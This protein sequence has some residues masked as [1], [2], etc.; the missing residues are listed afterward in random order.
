[1]TILP[2]IL[3]TRTLY[4]E[5]AA[6]LSFALVFSS[7]GVAAE[8][9]GREVLLSSDPWAGIEEMVVVGAGT[10]LL[11]DVIPT[12][13]IGFDAKDLAMERIHNVSDLGQFTPNLEIKTSFAA[14]NPVIFVRGV[15]LD[16][17]N[18][19]SAGAV[20]IYQDGVYMNSPAGQLFGFFDLAGVDV[21]RGAQSGGYR[22]ASAAAILANSRRPGGEYEAVAS[23]T[24]GNYDL[25]ETEL[26]V[27]IPLGE[28]LSSRYAGKFEKRSGYVKNRCNGQANR[29]TGC[30]ALNFPA[31][32]SSSGYTQLGD[33]T[34]VHG[35]V[36]D[37]DNWAARA[38]YLLDF[39]LGDGSME[40][41]LNIHGG[42][43]LGQA[44][45]FQH[46]GFR[47][48]SNN[49]VDKAY[50][51]DRLGYQDT[52][53]GRTRGDQTG[54]P[55]A[56]DYNNGGDEKLNLLG[57]SLQGKWEISDIHTIKSISAVEWHDRDTLENTDGGPRNLLTSR[58]QDDAW[59]FSQDLRLDSS[60]TE[61]LETTIGAYLLREDLDA[62]NLY[63]T[64]NSQLQQE[65][66]QDTRS[67]SL[68]G[69]LTWDLLSW[70]LGSWD[71]ALT[72]AGS[73]R[74]TH[75]FKQLETFTFAGNNNFGPRGIGTNADTGGDTFTGTSGSA[76]LTYDILD[77][78]NLYVKY[79]RGWKPGHINGGA[80]YSA[81]LV[82]PVKP[83]TIDAYEVGTAMSFFED[84]LKLSAAYF[85]TEFTDLQIFQLEQDAGDGFPLPQLIS[86]SGALI[87]GFEAELE[88]EPVENLIVAFNMGYLNT[89]YTDFV[90]VLFL[91][92][93]RS[94]D[95]LIPPTFIRQEIVY[96]GNPMISAP[97]WQLSG[98]VQYALSMGRAGILTPRFSFSW[99]DETFFNASKGRGARGDLPEGTN[100]QKAYALLHASLAWANSSESMSITGW[101]RNIAQQ[102]YRVTSFDVS[103]RAFGFVLDVY[104]P[105]RTFGVTLN[106]KY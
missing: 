73:V 39:P 31:G 82:E 65:Y 74:Y 22:N 28:H 62:E 67:W 26:A 1:M 101:V 35:H 87:W 83:E 43:N 85:Y 84:R 76:S 6:T 95:P 58:Y 19:N 91:P 44:T 96:T 52:D 25:I 38:Q 102:K 10:A 70:S 103:D 14:V 64:Q 5:M 4:G 50:R 49:T 2:T 75:E 93:A 61:Y 37:A 68:F 97:E 21:L 63:D 89:E 79:T 32:F 90:N 54:N 9:D 53:G 24:Y 100:G 30:S 71:Q 69:N 72:F 20:A 17:F 80:L 94:P 88:A 34:R 55:W 56:G 77:G 60:W 23:I 41:L 51:P 86:A 29:L 92:G 59:Q 66:T 106:L 78:V 36:N 7:L 98:S 47:R 104:G 15:G 105:P 45:Q 12:S 99:K 48:R 16:D 18:A 33:P 40:W 27:N 11:E 8:D 46:R 42:Q 13:A 3:R 81:Q 57:G